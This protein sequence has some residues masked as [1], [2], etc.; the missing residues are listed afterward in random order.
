MFEF[1]ITLRK[2][3]A[4]AITATLDDGQTFDFSGGNGKSRLKNLTG[5]LA[6]SSS[7]WEQ[8][9]FQ[10]DVES[11]EGISGKIAFVVKGDMVTDIG[12]QQVSVKNIEVP[13]GQLSITYDFA[14]KRMQ[15]SIVLDASV[16][17]AYT[18][19]GSADVRFD[20]QGWFFTAYGSVGLYNPNI[21]FAVGI[22]FG[23]YPNISSRFGDSKQVCRK[24]MEARSACRNAPDSQ[25]LQQP[26]RILLLGRSDKFLGSYIAAN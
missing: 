13:F 5:G 22:V 16:P 25:C 8:F 2:T 12:N 24:P 7:T 23:K 19:A 15:G 17:N 11:D 18:L 14:L 10:G 6:V 3:P 9:K 21:T 4:G 20:P 26:Q 1:N